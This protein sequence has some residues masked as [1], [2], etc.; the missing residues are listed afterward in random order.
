MTDE[1]TPATTAA[2]H[3]AAGIQSV[4]E[5]FNQVAPHAWEVLVRQQRVE[6]VLDAIVAGLLTGGAIA[7]IRA[8]F[9]NKKSWDEGLLAVLGVVA[10]VVGLF[11]VIF[12]YRA[13]AETLNP[14][15]YAMKE[16]AGMVH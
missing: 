13:A 8:C 3:L 4:A 10:A 1:L 6:A 14:E 7:L 15:F 16:I 9:R 12:A 2:D 11:G 5:A